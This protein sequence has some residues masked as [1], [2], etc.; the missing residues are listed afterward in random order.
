MNR[1][2]FNEKN[3]KLLLHITFVIPILPL[4]TKARAADLAVVQTTW[5]WE[6]IFREEISNEN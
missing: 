6:L 5:M 2:L 4:D 1:V 3:K